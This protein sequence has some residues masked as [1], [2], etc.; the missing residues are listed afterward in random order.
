MGP[1][2]FETG[3]LGL[4]LRF[5]HSGELVTFDICENAWP[6]KLASFMVGGT[7]SES[8]NVSATEPFLPSRLLFPAEFAVPAA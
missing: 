6:Y 4:G 1:R 5:D 8:G 3:V 7:P 2:K